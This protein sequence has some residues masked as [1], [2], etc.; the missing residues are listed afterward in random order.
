M[1]PEPARR[2][3]FTLVE[4]LVVIGVVS[5]LAAI[6]L[7]AVQSA[8][9]SSRRAA[10]AVNLRQIGLALQA[11]A[12]S[13]NAFSPGLTSFIRNPHG[14]KY[15]QVIYS[16]EFSVHTRYLPA[17][18]LVDIYNAI[19]FDVGAAPLT[20]ITATWK[21]SSRDVLAYHTNETAMRRR[22]PVFLCPSDGGRVQENG[23]NYRVN[24]GVG[25]YPGR[26]FLHPDSGNGFFHEIN[27]IRPVDI[28]DGMSNT[29][30]FSERLVG[31]GRKP[32]SPTRDYWPI[33][34]G[35]YGTA[36]DGLV[37]CQ[38]GARPQYQSGFIFG[39]DCWFWMGED[40]TEYNH[41]QEPNGSIPDCLVGG[42]TPPT[43][44]ST[45]RSFHP[46]GVNALLGDGSVRFFRETLSRETWRALGTRNGGEIVD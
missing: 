43:G 18:D 39:G 36:D 19:N 11:Y 3:G 33:R 2:R 26:S 38:V 42:A 16:G 6:S 12:A 10:C 31:S 29:V 23:V 21:P 17:L 7:P 14:S 37:A 13:A 46:G 41:A 44:V 32:M 28:T 27:M 30:A 15:A 24:V 1:I 9:E 45:A 20:S 25:G 8:R 5:L 40:R 22:I 34:T 35:V 4:L